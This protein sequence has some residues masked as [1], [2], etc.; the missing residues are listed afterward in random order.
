MRDCNADLRAMGA[1]E[2]VV[3][4]VLRYLSAERDE[5]SAYAAWNV[6]L[7]EEEI[8]LAARALAQAVGDAPNKPVQW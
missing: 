5:E 2:K 8:S 3:R 6:E 4:A 1:R 7:A